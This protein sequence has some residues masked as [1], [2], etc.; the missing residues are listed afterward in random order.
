[1]ETI[2][3]TAKGSVEVLAVRSSNRS[4]VVRIKDTP[5]EKSY[6]IRFTLEP[7][8]EAEYAV[9]TAPVDMTK[10][11]VQNRSKNDGVSAGATK[12]PTA[13]SPS[14]PP[15]KCLQADRARAN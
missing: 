15:S 4:E 13:R 1:M 5:A 9:L 6:T 3:K 10:E 11:D 12:T 2:N 8:N 7:M 14:K